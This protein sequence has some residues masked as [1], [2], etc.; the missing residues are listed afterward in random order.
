[1]DELAL[2]AGLDPVAYRLSVLA[3]PRA[4]A[5][6]E[7]VAEMSGWKSGA[8]PLSALSPGGGDAPQLTLSPTGG[9]GRVRGS[10]AAG[11]GSTKGRG[12]AFARYKARRTSSKAA[13]SR[14]SAGP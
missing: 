4:R 12:I 7:K 11:G 13:S 3:D 1:M 2:E 14:R 6:I 10:A 9:E 5:V 8:L